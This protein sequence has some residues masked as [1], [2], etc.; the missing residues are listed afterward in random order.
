VPQHDGPHRGDHDR[1][2]GRL[3]GPRTERCAIDLVV[4]P[5][6][7]RLFVRQQP[8]D[9]LD[10]LTEAGDPLLRAPV[11]DAHHPIRGI[12]HQAGPQADVEPAAGDVIGRQRLQ[13]K[14]GGVPQGNLG[15]Q[16]RQANPGG[17]LGNGGNL[18]PQLE[19]RPLV[20]GPID[21]M[22][23]EADAVEP[24]L[25]DLAAAAQEFG[26]G[27]VW[28]HEHGKSESVRHVCLP[29]ADEAI[30]PMAP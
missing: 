7:R 29:V 9:D 13:R 1:G 4:A 10:I 30:L 22:V 3:D 12:D 2:T 26:P 6:E 19:P 5:L 20:P 18:G 28:Q 21:K 15:D 16:G 17:C 24:E 8:I 27:H 23:G 14:V 11:L 25:L